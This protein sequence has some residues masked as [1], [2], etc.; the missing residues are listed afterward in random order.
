MKRLSLFFSSSEGRDHHRQS[1]DHPFPPPPPI[2]NDIPPIP[3]V[4][5]RSKSA[6]DTH[7]RTPTVSVVQ[8]SP[9]T[10]YS[11]KARAVSHGALTGPFLTPNASTPSLPFL[12]RPLPPQSPMNPYSRPGTASGL[13]ENGTHPGAS[14]ITINPVLPGSALNSGA[15]GTGSTRS[16]RPPTPN[17]L[18]MPK[19]PKKKKGRFGKRKK[20]EGQPAV[21]R[22]AAGGSATNLE[23][24][25]AEPLTQGESVCDSSLFCFVFR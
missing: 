8:S 16:S 10:R 23:P 15:T 24:Y 5:T 14:A 1:D 7:H 17:I 21:W 3:N 11:S 19:L 22:L 20:E 25:D 18:E 6:N 4:P 12:Q 13:P 9:N 2:P